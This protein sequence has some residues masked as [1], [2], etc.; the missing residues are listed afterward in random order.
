M[1]EHDL[2]LRPIGENDYV[3]MREARPIGR[4][5]LSDER[6]GHTTWNWSITVPLPIPSFGVG[7]AP[8]MEAAKTEFRSAWEAFYARLT[9]SDIDHWHR[10]Q[11]GALLGKRA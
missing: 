3:V 10:T 7:S 8:T 5:R 11:D 9:P 4:I 6:A 1:T 2:A